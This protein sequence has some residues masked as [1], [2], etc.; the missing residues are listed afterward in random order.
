MAKQKD[1]PAETKKKDKIAFETLTVKQT[2]EALKTNIKTGLSEEEARI[3]LEKYGKNQL[4][5]KKKKSWIRIFFEQMNNPMIFVLFAAIVVTLGISIFET[6]NCA[7]NGWMIEGE[8]GVLTPITNVFLQVGDW[9]DVIIILAVIILNAVIGTVQ[10][11]KAQN[12]LEALKKLSSP[13]STVIRDGK[14]IKIKSSDLVIGDIIVLEEGD[15]IGA[16][17]RL[18]ESV[19]LKVNES[20]LT[21]ESVPVEKDCDITFSKKTPIGDRINMAYMSTPITYG[22]G[23]GIVT[24]TGMNTEI[25]TIAHALDNEEEQMTPLQKSLA[26]LSK[27]L[28]ILAL[29]VVVLVL[30]AD[31]AWIFGDGKMGEMETWLDAIISSIALAVAAIP[32]GLPAVVTIVLAI[33]VQRMVKANTVVRKLNSVETLGAV[34]VVCSDKTGTLTQNKMT[35]VEAYAD[36]K[37]FVLDHFNKE[38]ETHDL[39]V[40]ARGMSLCSNATVD[41]GLYGDPTEIALV[42][43]ANQFGLNKS[44]IE[45]RTPRID[46][47]P[48]DSVRKMMSTKHKID[49]GKTVTFTKGALDSILKHTKEI[50]DDGKIRPITKEDIEAI[51]KANKYFSSKALRVLA[52]AFNQKDTIDEKDLVFV[53]LTAMIDP[54]RPEAKPA[55]KTFKDAG[56]TTVMITGDHKDTA[57]AIAKDLGIVSDIN[58]CAMGEEIDNLSEEE[59]RKLCETVRVFA[60]VSPE[61]KVAIVK[62]FEANGNI[63]AMTGDGVNDAPSLKAADIG[64]AMG[65]TGTDVAKGAADMVL[66]D[67]NFA[68]IEKAVEE[69]RGIYANIKKTVLFLLSSN[70]AEVLTMFLIVCIGFPTPFLAIHL[71]WVNLITDSLPAIALGMDP[72][73]PKIMEDKPRDPKDGILAKGGMR[74]MLIFGAVITIAVLISYFVAAFVSPEFYSEGYANQGWFGIKNFYDDYQQQLHEAQTMAFTTLAVCELFHML[75]MSNLNRSFIHVFKNKNWMMLIAFVAGLALQLFVIMTPGVQE[76]FSTTNL[77][78]QEWLITCALAILPLVAHEIYVF[79]KWMIKRKHERDN[80][81]VVN[82]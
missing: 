81:V 79:I 35:V 67:D 27:L 2:E 55:V 31:I 34:S 61:N 73:D 56:I 12:S 24:S 4:E 40:L 7:H 62:A 30:I 64:I 14:R 70:I 71:L 39:K 19:N 5:E 60:R 21:G 50:L 37:F 10:E 57:F 52:L 65:I 22:R 36:N 46:E 47:L 69:G 20:S 44:I 51:H 33:G 23:K 75:G 48:F 78:W 54:A 58:Q 82:Q 53:G 66:T 38:N 77:T 25:G 72:K 74:D 8:N 49:E 6:I 59:L 42:V 26:K 68:S 15:T 28:G 32:E 1:N 45:E 17:I 76:V 16:D 9:P 11:V 41:E 13:E 29:I 18:I 3:R 63:C 43:F 80:S